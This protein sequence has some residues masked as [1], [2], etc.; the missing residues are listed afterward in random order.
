MVRTII[1][2]SG[3]ALPP[4][5]VANEMLSRIM[6]VDDDWIRER[7]GVENRFFVDEGTSTSDLGVAA[8]PNALADAGGA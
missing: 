5:R 4:N 8:A 1:A 2:G 6:D 7:S 3:I